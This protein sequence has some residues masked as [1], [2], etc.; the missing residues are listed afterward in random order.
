MGQKRKRPNSD[1]C[2]SD[3][4]EQ[5]DSDSEVS[6]EAEVDMSDPEEGCW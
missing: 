1:E 4:K 6:S 3:L 2:D 5:K